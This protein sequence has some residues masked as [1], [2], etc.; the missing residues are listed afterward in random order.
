[1]NANEIKAQLA[2]ITKEVLVSTSKENVFRS[3]W[4][5]LPNHAKLS[6]VYTFTTKPIATPALWT[7]QMG[8]TE[9]EVLEEAIQRVYAHA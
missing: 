4:R 1:M 7:P 6:N 3:E 5:L 2:Q 9:E 8:K